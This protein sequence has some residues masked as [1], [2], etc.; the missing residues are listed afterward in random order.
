MLRVL[1]IRFNVRSEKFFVLLHKLSHRP[2]RVCSN[3]ARSFTHHEMTQTI[4]DG[5]FLII[6]NSTEH[7]RGERE[8]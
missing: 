8:S 1:R 6:F 7:R 3:I 5:L 4:E 2:G